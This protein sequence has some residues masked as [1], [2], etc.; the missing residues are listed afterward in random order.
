M[1]KVAVD[2]AVTQLETIKIAMENYHF[3]IKQNHKNKDVRLA[4]IKNIIK[5]I[6]KILADNNVD[7]QSYTVFRGEGISSSL[8][9]KLKIDVQNLFKCTK[10]NLQHHPIFSEKNGHGSNIIVVFDDQT[11]N[12]WICGVNDDEEL[13]FEKKECYIQ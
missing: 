7:L 8:F 9:T 13:N 2:F 3:E 10:V 1:K 5:K 4:S 11:E 6:D 12:M